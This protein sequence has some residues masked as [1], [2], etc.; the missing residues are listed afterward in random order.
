V[1]VTILKTEPK[2]SNHG[3]SPKQLIALPEILAGKSGIEVA[4]IVGVLPQTIS[5]WL[6]H[7]AG[8]QKALATETE[9]ALAQ[10]RRK[11]AATVNDAVDTLA[12]TVRTGS[13]SA[14]RTK[15]AISVLDRAGLVAPSEVGNAAG[16]SPAVVALMAMLRA[17]R[18]QEEKVS[19]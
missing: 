7:D 19:D 16:L 15:A 10:A 12:D 14:N 6:N 11:L 5:E 4:K 18:H 1:S 2:T 3:L 8:F 17:E 13:G 9:S